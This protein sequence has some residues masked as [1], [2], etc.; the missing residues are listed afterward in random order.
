MTG[1][2]P[3]TGLHLAPFTEAAEHA[4]RWKA[5]RG[6]APHYATGHRQWWRCLA[7][8]LDGCEWHHDDRHDAPTAPDAVESLIR[9]HVAGHDLADV[10][11]SLAAARDATEAVR[12]SSDRAWEVV[13]LHRLRAVQ[14]GEGPYSDPVAQMLSAALVGAE[15]HQAV[16]DRLTELHR[17]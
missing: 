9:E 1:H 11:T 7:C 14:R 12:A 6:R 10:L 2:G 16:R 17:G 4:G 13:Q 3:T 5:D 8:P 15:E